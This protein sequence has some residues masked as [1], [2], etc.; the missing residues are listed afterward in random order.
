MFRDEKKQAKK[1]NTDLVHVF[2]GTGSCVMKE[3]VW[4]ILSMVCIKATLYDA[5]KPDKK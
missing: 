3:T 4:N 1:N 2:F 5:V